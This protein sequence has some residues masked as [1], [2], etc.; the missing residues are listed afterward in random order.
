MYEEW[1]EKIS[2]PFRSAAA[3]RAVNVLDKLLVYI[4]AA[5]YLGMVAWLIV[6]GDMRAVKAI[7]VPALTFALVTVIRKT[8]DA[9]RPYQLHD[10]DPIIHKD[11]QGQSMP[12]RHISSAVII[13]CAEAWIWPAWGVVAGVLCLIVAFC[14]VVGGVHFPR[15][16]VAAIAIALACGVVGFWLIP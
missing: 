15:D 5:V 11:R 9:P 14:R 1:Y 4:I 3:A 13:A 2:E 12:S 10:I 6:G 8:I 7:A 16:V